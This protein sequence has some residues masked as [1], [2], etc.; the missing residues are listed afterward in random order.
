M[1]ESTLSRR[2][3]TE[4]VGMLVSKA[5][6]TAWKQDTLLLRFLEKNGANAVFQIRG[7]A[8]DVF[9]TWEKSRIY[10][11]SVPP[12]VVRH[13]TWAPKNGVQAQFE[14]HLVFPCPGR[15]SSTAWPMVYRYNFCDWGDL[16]QLEAGAF[17]DV[18]GIAEHPVSLVSSGSSGIRKATLELRNGAYRQT[19]VLLG[20]HAGVAAQTGDVVAFS[21]LVVREYR[22]ERTLQTTL[23]A[24]VELNPAAREGIPAVE[25]ASDERPRKALKM[26]E[27]LP[28]AISELA[29]IATELQQSTAGSE[30]TFQ[31][32]GTFEK[33]DESFFENDPPVVEAGD[34]T[35]RM[36]WR[37]RF[38]DH[39]A[40]RVVTVWD[41]ACESIF[42]MSA[43]V[44]RDHWCAGEGPEAEQSSILA[45]LNDPLDSR[46]RCA[47]SASL[48]QG[49]LQVNVNLAE[50]V[51]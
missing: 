38:T 37:V 35:L 20:E 5:R 36:K 28:I 11:V 24:I 44:F 41:R 49:T 15:V 17:V 7:N 39:S 25:A 6:P 23:L 21:G 22:Q 9:Q 8:I 46:Y 31:L 10:E 32:V 50:A 3:K 51:V 43:S 47:C 14:V 34:Q 48:W 27:L 1:A 19:I 4:F 42:H 40:S 26:A 13:A 12:T 45:K 2:K 16:N 33:F 29:T 18:I 30:R